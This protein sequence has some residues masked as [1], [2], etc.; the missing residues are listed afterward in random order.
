MDPVK[1][2]SRHM[3]PEKMELLEPNA[4]IAGRQHGTI[5]EAG[6]VCEGSDGYPQVA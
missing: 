3:A 5:E 1:A 6:N 4:A 2:K